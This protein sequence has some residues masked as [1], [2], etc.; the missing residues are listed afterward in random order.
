MLKTIH[1]ILAITKWHFWNHFLCYL[2]VTLE[3][4]SNH[5]ATC[6]KLPSSPC[7]LASSL[8]KTTHIFFMVGANF[9][10]GKVKNIN[11]RTVRKSSSKKIC[12][13]SLWCLAVF[14]AL[15]VSMCVYISVISSTRSTKKI[16]RALQQPNSCWQ[17]WWKTQKSVKQPQQK[18]TRC[19][20]PSLIGSRFLLY[21]IIREAPTTIYRINIRCD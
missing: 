17:I 3:H 16:L 7:K 6:L 4:P 1:S 18:I 19:L 15:W 9:F 21:L 8:L 14:S 11:T 13:R 10:F 2:T 5:V 12:Q 20:S